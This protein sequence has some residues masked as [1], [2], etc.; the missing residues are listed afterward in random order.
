MKYARYIQSPSLGATAVNGFAETASASGSNRSNLQGQPYIHGL[1]YI[2]VLDHI[3]AEL[4]IQTRA[5]AGTRYKGS[6]ACC[7]TFEGGLVIPR[8]VQCVLPRVQELARRVLTNRKSSGLM[9]I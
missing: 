8:L 7:L 4:G 3:E 5:R 6:V 1:S 2:G 9:I